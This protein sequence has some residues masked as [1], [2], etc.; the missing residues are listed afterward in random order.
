MLLTDLQ[1]GIYNIPLLTWARFN[2]GRIIMMFS[3]TLTAVR[4][5]A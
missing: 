2:I 3:L 4:R 5:H 1:Q